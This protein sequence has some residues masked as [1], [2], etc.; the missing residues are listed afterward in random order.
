M[1]FPL[2]YC[3]LGVF[4]FILPTNCLFFLFLF[5]CYF[6][7]LLLSLFYL[8]FYICFM[9]VLR[10]LAQSVENPSRFRKLIKDVFIAICFR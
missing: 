7:L 9:C 10:D 5:F 2:L 8:C 6:Y 3:F 1:S 4:S